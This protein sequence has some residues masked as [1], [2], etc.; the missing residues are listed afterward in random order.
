MNTDNSCLFFTTLY[1]NEVSNK[2]RN[3]LESICK[4]QNIRYESMEGPRKLDRNYMMYMHI[5]NLLTRFQTSNYEYGIICDDDTSINDN[6]FEEVNKTIYY[7][8]QEWRALHLGPGWLWGRKFGIQNNTH[9]G[10]MNPEGSISDLDLDLSKR[11]FKNIH[12]DVW[13]RKKIWPGGSIAFVIK[14]SKIDELITDYDETWYR[15][16]LPND[17]LFLH[18]KCQ[19]DFICA[20]PLLSYEND[21]GGSTYK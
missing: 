9:K 8:P 12:K 7:L 3:H 4:E 14:K 13:I 11:Y 18:M 19:F 6:F 10:E 2:R 15:L 16:K 1:D 21:Q 17:R 5:K 20:Y